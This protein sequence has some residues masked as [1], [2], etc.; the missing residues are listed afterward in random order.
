MG[1]ESPSE[2]EFALRVILVGTQMLVF[3]LALCILA[4]ASTL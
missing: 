2:L 4:L 1:R 3:A